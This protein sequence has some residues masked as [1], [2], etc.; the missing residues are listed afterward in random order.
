MAAAASGPKQAIPCSRSA[1]AAPAT[2]GASGPITTRSG[3]ELAG[4]RDDPGRGRRRCP[5]GF[6]PA[7]RC[8]GCPARRAGCRGR[9]AAS[10]RTIACSRPPDPM[11]RMRTPVS[12]PASS[13]AGGRARRASAAGPELEGLVAARADA[14]RADRGA[15]H[16]LHGRDVG[17][18]VRRQVVERLGLAR[19]PPTSRRGTRR[20]ARAWWNSVCVIGI[21]SCRLPSTS[22]ATQTG[23]LLQAGQHVQLGQ[24]VAGDPVHP[25]RVAGDDR[26]EPAGS[27]GPGRWSRRTPRRSCAATRPARRSARWGT[28]PRRPGWCTP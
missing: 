13:A 14:D 26:V 18:R 8:R 21:S 23:T 15:D 4:Q 12:L 11:T 1:S 7:P 25:G 28:G 20:P 17:P 3:A 24:E 2:S 27:G 10:A 16:L 6:R 5:G 22:Y 9:I 19:C